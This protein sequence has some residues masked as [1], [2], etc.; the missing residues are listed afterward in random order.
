MV[1][2]SE[3]GL[4]S[5]DQS[6]QPRGRR[7]QSGKRFYELVLVEHRRGVCKGIHVVCNNGNSLHSRLDIYDRRYTVKSHSSQVESM[8]VG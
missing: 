5:V 4:I 7:K 1:S 3:Y 2:W 8:G 6:T